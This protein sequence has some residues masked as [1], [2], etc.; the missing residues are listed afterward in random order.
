[1]RDA[2]AGEAAGEGRHRTSVGVVREVEPDRRRR[3]WEGSEAMTGAPS[4]EMSPIR[5]IG[6]SGRRSP[7]PFGQ[8]GGSASELL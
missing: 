4:L 7:C 1:V 3:G 5:A 8:S 6:S 2:D